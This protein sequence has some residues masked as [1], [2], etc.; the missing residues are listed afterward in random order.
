MAPTMSAVVESD[1]DVVQ[2]ERN[3]DDQ[4]HCAEEQDVDEVGDDTWKDAGDDHAVGGRA[5]R[6]GHGGRRG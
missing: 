4:S 3:A 2:P 1:A 6:G 5:D